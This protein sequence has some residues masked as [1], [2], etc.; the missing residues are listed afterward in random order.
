MKTKKR[1]YRCNLPMIMAERIHPDYAFAQLD[2]KLAQQR[3]TSLI[4]ALHQQYTHTL[5]CIADA[6]LGS[7][8]LKSDPLLLF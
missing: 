6:P 7:I 5:A 2:Q 8:Q 1:S 4:P 3:E